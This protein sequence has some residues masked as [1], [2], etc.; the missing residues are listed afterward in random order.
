M[1][2]D[3]T[4]LPEQ[5]RS[6]SDGIQPDAPDD[7]FMRGYRFG[8][9]DA[10]HAAAELAAAALSAAPA[11]EPAVEHP[12]EEALRSLACWM[13]VGGYNAPTVDAKLYEQKI[14]EGV[15][16][17][18]QL[19]GFAARDL[20]ETVLHMDLITPKGIRAREL[21]R[22]VLGI[23]PLPQEPQEGK[24]LTDE[25]INELAAEYGDELDQAF[26]FNRLG[27]FSAVAFAR[28]IER[29]LRWAQEVKAGEDERIEAVRQWL[30][31]KHACWFTAA[32]LREMFAVAMSATLQPNG[33]QKP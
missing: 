17:Y 19:H 14:R 25:R 8:H 21:A 32:S 6:L 11:Q 26:I 20:A 13:G 2:D 3:R 31:E 23:V 30:I 15:T 4:L 16:V 18:S 24:A 33:E 27:R 10:R 5:I 28:G 12:A 1:N 7:S 29:E 22:Q 9:R